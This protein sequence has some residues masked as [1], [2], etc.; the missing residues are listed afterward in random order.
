MY[1]NKDYIISIRHK[2]HM[3]P[4]IG[5]DLPETTALIKE[6]LKGMNIEY[7]ESYAQSSIVATINP[8]KDHFTIGIRADMDALPVEEK[9]NLTFKSKIDN[10]MHACGHDAHTAILL[11]T[12]KALKEMEDKLSCRVMLIFQPA[13]EIGKGAG[14]L[15]KGG[16]MDEIDVIVGLHVE[17]S[18][19]SGT[20]GVCKGSSV[21]SCRNFKLS[22]FGKTSHATSPEVAIDALSVAV[23]TYNNIQHMLTREVSPLA[24]YVCSIGKLEG[25]ISHNIIADEAHMLCTL[26]TFDMDLDSFLIKRIA[27]IAKNSASE[28]GAEAELK[29]DMLIYDVYNNPYISDLILASAEKIIGKN[30][31]VD[32]PQKLTSEDFSCYL[33]KKPGVLMRLGTRNE[34]KNCTTPPH[35]GNFMIDEDAFEVGADTFV[36]FVLDNMNGIDMNEVEKTERKINFESVIF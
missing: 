4:E 25:G 35:T 10:R 27:D 30:R 12:A 33:S 14:E 7:T 15:V 28:V 6:E 17:N 16:V 20:I 23:R 22:F 24:K 5:F 21:A 3:N 34:E 11:G 8:K 18:L 1:S 19:P 9:T 13:E 2:L 29:I 36:Q 26:R 31:I 32:M